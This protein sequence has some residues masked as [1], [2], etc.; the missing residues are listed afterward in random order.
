MT[1]ALVLMVIRIGKPCFDFICS[2]LQATET[3]TPKGAGRVPRP[4]QHQFATFLRFMGS[5]DT[6][7][8]FRTAELT[9]IGNGS[10]GNYVKRVIVAF[11]EIQHQYLAWLNAEQRRK[12]ALDFEIP[13]LVGSID[14][15][16]F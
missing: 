14:C 6:N 3:F 8:H 9:A 5:S 16:L 1:F 13:G 11:R 12:T 10:V 7:R 15:C 4:V 2:L